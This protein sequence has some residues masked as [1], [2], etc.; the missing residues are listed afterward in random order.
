ME[1]IITKKLTEPYFHLFDSKNVS[2][3]EKFKFK[4]FC[5]ILSQSVSSENADLL[6]PTSDDW[7]IHSS[8]YFTGSKCSNAYKSNSFDKMEL[9]WKKKKNICVFRGSAT[10]CGMTLENNMRLKAAQ[11]SLEHP[12]LLDAG[13]TDWKPRDKKFSGEPIKII[14][15]KDFNFSLA[16]SLSMD[17]QTKYKYIFLTNSDGDRM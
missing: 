15:P 13:I 11:L 9:D 14:N 4:K 17:E 2:I 16:D 1:D 7:R 10:G 3:E 12:K 8:K 5:P 6:I